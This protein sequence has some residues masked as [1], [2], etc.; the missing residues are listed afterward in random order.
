MDS[1]AARNA[2]ECL[3]LVFEMSNILNTQLDRHTI[4]LLI[5]LSE[6]GFNPEALA[7]LVKE[8]PAG[9]VSSS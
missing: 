3:D 2:K 1:K 4:S 9:T 8:L 5:A 7:A 6:L